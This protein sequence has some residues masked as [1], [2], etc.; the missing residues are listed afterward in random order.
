MNLPAVI[1][2]PVEDAAGLLFAFNE[3]YEESARL[4]L[5]PDGK[6]SWPP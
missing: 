4:T 3:G 5:E 1:L 2:Y 6:A